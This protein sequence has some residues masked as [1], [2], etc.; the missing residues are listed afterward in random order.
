M[1]ITFVHQGREHLGLE[2]LTALLK[3]EEHE[4]SLIYD[5]G[6]FGPND[7][8]FYVPRLE[9]WLQDPERLVEEI[10]A[11]A[12]DLVGFATFTNT[13]QWALDLARRV[14]SRLDAPIIFGGIHATLV[15]D[16]VMENDVVDYVLVGEGELAFPEL[17]ARLEAG[18]S[19]EGVD[20]LWHRANRE[21]VAQA[22][23]PAVADLDTLPYPD[24]TLFERF[25]NIHDDYLVLTTRG[26]PQNCAYC[27]ESFLNRLYH[28]KFFRRRS[29]GNVLAELRERQQRYRFREVMFNDSIFFTDKEWLRELLTGLRRDLGVPYRCFGQVR[30]FD[31]EI[32]GLLKESGC[33]AIEFG[34]QTV[35]ETIRRKVLRRVES[36]EQNRRAFEICDHFGLS[37]DVDHMFGLPGETRDDDHAA[38]RFYA[39]FRR[40]N[41]IKC[42]NLVYFPRLAITNYSLRKGILQEADVEA[43]EQGEVTDFFHVD[44]IASPE[45]QREKQAFDKLLKLLPL[46]GRRGTEYLLRDRR[47]LKLRS[48]PGIATMALQVLVAL[49][50][51]DYRFLLYFKYY[52]LRIR[53]A[54]AARRKP[55]CY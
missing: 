31:E 51:R 10:C 29:P 17:C 8:V 50:H 18:K 53:R 6:L 3:R 11:S 13:Y 34:V 52:P 28:G 2:Y 26:C 49:L 46:L 1:R 5:Q 21:V 30:F 47:Y 55:L 25:V 20:N 54:L 32:A 48:L 16:R 38:A 35:N 22:P 36:N 43:V 15:P 12:P 7:N 39:Q 44:S 40:L 27:C 24:K 33:Y 42:H 19:V 14:K 9:Q 45:R 37:Y 23:G 41:R 4:I